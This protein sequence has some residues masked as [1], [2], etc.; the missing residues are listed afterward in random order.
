[1]AV[2]TLVKNQAPYKNV[3][4]ND[5]ILDKHGKKM[6]KHVGN[7]VNPFEMFDK[8][9]ADASRW[10]LLSTSPAWTPT[11]FDEDGLKDIVSKFF[12]TL[13][14]VYNFFVLYSNQDD[15]DCAALDVKAELRTELDKWILSKYNRL[16]EKVLFEMEQYDHMKTVHAI[17][18]FVAEDLSN[19]YIRRARRRFW[20]SEMND[21]KK[22]VYATTYEILKGVAKL[23]APFA[24]FLSDEIYTNLTGEY[25]VH[26]AYYPEVDRS[27][28]NEA[29]ENRMDLVRS[30][31]SLGRGAREKEQ[32]KVRQPISRIILDKKNEDMISD[33]NPLIME[34]LNVKEVVYE[35]D[36]AKYMSYSIKPDFKTAGPVLGPK[37]KVFG[38]L[39]AESVPKEFMNN[40]G[41]GITLDLDGETFEITRDMVDLRIV[42]EA[43]YSVGIDQDI[44]V[45][46]ATEL[47]P[48]LITEGLARE[49]VSKVQQLRKQHELEMM[50]NIKIILDAGDEVKKAVQEYKDYIM[51]E[52]LATSLDYGKTEESFKVNGHETGIGIEKV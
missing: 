39:L 33:L 36:M 40:I 14:N 23:M 45:A 6:S 16:V 26:T 51:T 27:L 10:Y 38:K 11:K 41:S 9:G 48:E 46:V 37:V 7:T 44:S 25:T 15:I 21:D 13:R 35:E 19:W 42:S 1:M 8:Y 12:G 29:I 3:L 49:I 18:D 17:Q 24:P 28:I 5:L 34:E 4:V 52:T 22:S 32:I 43:G 31:V 20:Q 2:S 30:I 50:D 47:T